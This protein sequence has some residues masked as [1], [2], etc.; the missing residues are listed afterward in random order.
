[1]RAAVTR[2]HA[3]QSDAVASHD[4]V[5]PVEPGEGD[6]FV[7][8]FA[9]ASDAVAAALA[10]QRAQ[11]APIRLRIGVHTGEAELHQ[12]GYYTGPTVNQATLLRDLA[13]GG[14]TVLSG[15]TEDLTVDRL[16]DGAWLIDLG[17]HPLGDLRRSE[18]VVQLCHPDLQIEFPPL[19]TTLRTTDVDVAH[20][21]P[22]QLTS[23]IGRAAQ[24]DEVRRL[25]ADHRL[26]TLTGVGGVGKT[27]LAVQ[28]AAQAAG[29]FG[30]A[31]YVDLAPIT[32][33][34]LVP[35]TLARALGLR[36]QLGHPITDTILSFLRARRAL[37][38]LD[39]CE[40]LLDATTAL[41]VAVLE[42][43]RGVSLLATSR[44]PLGIAGEVRWRV[45]SL[46]VSD[47]ACQLFCDRA[48]RVR[49][50]F[51]LIGDHATAVVEICER[52]DGLPLAI[53]LAAARVR[54]L[55]LG[56]IIDGLR[57][58]F[59]LLTGGARTAMAR[60]QTLLASLDW[61]HTL[62][63]E[64]ERALFRRL[65]VFVGGFTLD[66]AQAVAGGAHVQR[67]QVLDELMLLVDKSLV[68]ADDS[69]GRTRYRLLETVR[70]YA[71][72]K[73][74]ESGDADDVRMR[75]RDHYAM[76]AGLLDVPD[77]ADYQ[78]HIEQADTE[79]DNLRA[80]FGWSREKADI[81][82]ALTLA[83]SLQP[84]WL[85]RGRI[86]EG[87]TWF[88][89]V[90]ADT[91][92]DIYAI[93]PAVRARALADRAMLDI[94]VDAT[95]GMAQAQQ[96]LAIA[97][98]VKDTAL[99][100]RAL[101]AC[102]LISVVGA[103][104]EV[105]A[106]YFDEAH[107]LARRINDR[108]RLSQILS[109]QAVDAI[110]A[111]RPIAV[112]KAAEEGRDLANAI[113]DRS[114]SRWCRLCLG[115]AQLMQGELAGAVAQ[116][117]EVANEAEESQDVMHRANSLQG[118]GYALAYQGHIDA[119]REAADAALEA[120]GLGE[121]FAG[122]GYSA[123]ATA[124]LAAGDVV[125]AREA[126]ESAWHNLGVAMPQ[127]TAVQRAFS[128]Q[129]A[130]A[131][132]DLVAARRWSDEAVQTAAGRH[133][134]VALT[135]RTRIAIAEGKRDDAERDARRALTCAADLGAYV[136]L[137]DVL[138]CLAGLASDAGSHTEAAR[139]FGAA[140]AIRQR[141]GLVRFGVYQAGYE[142]SVTALRDAMGELDF[143]A[144]WAEGAVLST[145]EAIDYA[146]RLRG[147][148]K[149]PTSGWESLTPAEF[150]VVRLVGEGLTNKDIATRL[151]VSHRTV[152]THLTH[153][154]SKLGLTS[155]VQLAKEA[156]SRT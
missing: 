130:L 72:E 116:F 135:A 153:V 71:L 97:R 31:W 143:D 115:F 21:F 81:E 92:H 13:H 108:W 107:G 112:R 68:A 126:S 8:A 100:A 134:A 37:L 63:S 137:P 101:T 4:G 9:R 140:E 20:G 79:M 104:V 111:G 27:R 76:L 74:D 80:A 57:D 129:V 42:T 44:E 17:N 133:L 145:E 14:Q 149:R 67:Y 118:L 154:Y 125:T 58:R 103:S 151:V 54:G 150:D 84:V 59:Q 7:I 50:D 121:Y 40:H 18:R 120:A 35:A 25:V 49:P 87:R 41:V 55:S 36:D 136:D 5:L 102:G 88:D 95:A 114:R 60:Q 61:S 33:P 30:G 38:L 98:E 73:L 43:C 156:G 96:A 152:Q 19:R 105:A 141:I 119:A 94:F 93:A 3:A 48:R 109:F 131:A 23:F 83:S 146:Q 46:P 29:E 78:R 52:L 117:R 124:A 45:R 12:A 22:V 26:V 147:R 56:E 132:G 142:A 62:L 15:A 138:E 39:N 47:E 2:L 128:A 34:D 99:L 90:L 64:H 65:G 77:S 148:R 85:T 75:H 32:D 28:V 139:L 6:S 82:I 113:G 51:R 122:M 1:M 11:L 24:I 155:R 53:E 123:L 127:S 69:G 144:A 16:P 110:L 86:R 106:P 66:A 89:T 70:Q 91:D 10:L